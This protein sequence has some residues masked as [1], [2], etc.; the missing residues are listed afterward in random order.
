MRTLKTSEAAALLNVVLNLL[1]IPRYGAPGAAVTAAVSGVILTAA[2][3]YVV[4]EMFGRL[5]LGRAFAEGRRSSTSCTFT[6]TT[7]RSRC[8]RASPR[9][10]SLPCTAGSTCRSISWCSG[11]SRRRR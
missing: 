2:A 1:L 9:R 10:F 3:I 4:Q 6:S 5:Q 7:I 11:R 8:S